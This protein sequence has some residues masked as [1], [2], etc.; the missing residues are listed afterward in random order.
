MSDLFLKNSVK[1]NN[2]LNSTESSL[3][4]NKILNINKV[5]KVNNNSVTSSAL[6]ENINGLSSTSY[7]SKQVGGNSVTSSAIMEN[8][9]GLSS[10]SYNSKQVGGNSI[11]SSAIMQTINELSSTSYNSKQVGGANITSTNL[12]KINSNDINN[13]L[14]MLT[15]ES[16]TQTATE[17]LENKLKNLLMQDGGAF[18]EN[19]ITDDMNTEELQSRIK[20][21]QLGGNNAILGLVGLAGLAAAG[22]IFS[23]FNAKT[24]IGE[25]RS[26]K[27][28]PV[29]NRSVA[30]PVR[31]RPVANRPVR[32]TSVT[33]SEMPSIF[34]K[35]NQNNQLIATTTEI[36]SS[37]TSSAMPD[38][39][40]EELYQDGG[41]HP[42]M[43]VYRD[44]C[45]LVSEKLE[46]SNG[47]KC[48][49]IAGQLQK[50]VKL[51]TPGITPDKL[52]KAA[53]NYL[54]DHINEY[55]KL[56]ST[57]GR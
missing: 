37:A 29:R 7:N 41:N 14:A 51:K 20:N 10:T 40:L 15:S 8:V 42:G 23:E 36:P 5:N 52:L 22:T 28:S 38:G 6:M 11:T 2:F 48:K 27:N 31:N 16:N 50:D 53:E 9:N 43:V 49:K 30:S 19:T 46:M 13:L 21:I 35:S 24:V 3:N 44:I 4:L 1:N 17:D 34:T 32:N 56:K 45:K 39:R 25:N 57:L 26:G 33:S 12:S 47:P 54:D 55:K 18:T